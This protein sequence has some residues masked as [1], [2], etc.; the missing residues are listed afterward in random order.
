LIS[1]IDRYIRDMKMMSDIRVRRK[2]G[3][4]IATALSLGFAAIPAAKADLIAYESFSG[5]INSNIYSPRTPDIGLSSWVKAGSGV[6]ITL[7]N[8]APP[9]YP[10]VVTVGLYGIHSSGNSSSS[11]TTTLSDP[12]TTGGTDIWVGYLADHDNNATTPTHS[13][14]FISA[15]NTD[16]SVSSS[17]GFWSVGG[18]ATSV[19]VTNWTFIVFHLS[20][21]DTPGADVVDWYVNPDATGATPTGAAASG[22][23]TGNYGIE[24]IRLSSRGGAKWDEIRIGDSFSG[25]VPEPSSLVFLL[26]GGTMVCAIRRRQA[27]LS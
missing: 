17:S 8:T 5:T 22:T 11:S 14:A 20:L 24:Q 4:I 27:R 12:Q 13:T 2:T 21:S 15:G 1:P 6:N 23:L 10:G 18:N 25:V 26:G 9:D 3:W 7:Q 16:F 19:S